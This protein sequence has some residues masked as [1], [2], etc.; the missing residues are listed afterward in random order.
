MFQM[1]G[2]RQCRQSTGVTADRTLV[3]VATPRPVVEHT[4][5][6]PLPIR[7]STARLRRSGRRAAV[8]DPATKFA[9]TV[10]EIAQIASSSRPMGDRPCELLDV[11]QRVIGCEAASIAVRDAEL[12]GLVPV[13]AIGDF[14]VLHDYWG[15]P[16]SDV[17]IDRVGL[18]RLSAPIRHVDLR[19]PLSETLFWAIYALPAGFRG[20]MSTGLFSR[21]GR[22][23]GNVSFLAAS[24]DR[25]TEADRHVVALVSPFLAHA[26][27]RMR[28]ITAA[29]MLV[30]D[31]T[32]G[33]VL[34]RSGAPLYCPAYPA[35]R[36]CRPVRP[37]CWPPST[38]SPSAR[39]TRRSSVRTRGHLAT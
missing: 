32:A 16:E 30:R 9:E 38:G 33:V 36:R 24:A 18:N 34:T 20:A 29:A 5:V 15:N 25:P 3:A 37:S 2:Y 39:S 7:R 27:D 31:A 11:L 17:E 19:M 1:N 13:G 35:I 28:S 21:D 22:H 6:L 8:S 4:G 14:G 12:P 23:V 26:V 10:T